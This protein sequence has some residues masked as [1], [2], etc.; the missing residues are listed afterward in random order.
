MST[1]PMKRHA[2]YI[3][4]CRSCGNHCMATERLRSVEVADE[5]AYSD[6][7]LGGWNGVQT[8]VTTCP[9]CG[10]AMSWRKNCV[11]ADL[12][13]Q[14]GDLERFYLPPATWGPATLYWTGFERYD[15]MFHPPGKPAKPGAPLPRLKQAPSAGDVLSLRKRAWLAR[16]LLWLDN[17]RER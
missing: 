13:R 17:D 5:V 11:S 6:G 15:V 2:E 7:Y 14:A 12:L 8:E 9:H 3:C 4:A 16:G 10:I 1:A